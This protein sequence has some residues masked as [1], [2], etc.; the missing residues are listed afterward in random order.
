M[1]I[2]TLGIGCLKERVSHGITGL[3][4]K[5][6]KEFANYT[7]QLFNDN[8]LWNKMKINLL[9]LR[10]SKQWK[11]IATNFIKKSNE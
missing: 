5:N 4:A 8:I 1:P 6:E 9:S 10:G 3:I 11:N 7:I 2:V